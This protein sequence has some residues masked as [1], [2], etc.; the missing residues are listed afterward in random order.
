VILHVAG[1]SHENRIVAHR[2]AGG[3]AYWEVNSAAIA[4]W[5]NQSRTIE[6]ANNRDGTLSIF[7]V[8]FDAATAPDVRTLSWTDDDPTAEPSGAINEPW[9]ASLARETALHDPQFSEAQLRVAEGQPRDRNAELLLA[10]PAWLERRVAP[11]TQ[12]PKPAAP[13]AL[14]AT[15][16]G[17]IA[18]LAV[19]VT[20]VMALCALRRR[21]VT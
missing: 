9:L 15:G 12:G 13:V 14:P 20:A 7:T 6:V 8:V 19:A 21:R 4:D 16:G 3:R 2:D 18:G 10:A 1:H 5:P 11:A 17:S